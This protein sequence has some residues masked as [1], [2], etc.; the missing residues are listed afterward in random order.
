M[1]EQPKV[2]LFREKSLEAVES[3]ESLNDYLRV[4]SVGVWLV[5]SAVIALLVG[6][7]LWG[8]LGRIDTKRQA[9]VITTGNKTI[10][11][12]PFESFDE[13]TMISERR[14]VEIGGVAYPLVLGEDG[15]IELGYLEE[16]VTEENRYSRIA[17]VSGLAKED[18][19]A[20]LPVDAS[21]EDGVQPGTVV[22]ESLQ[23]ISLI[24]R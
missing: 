10:C 23:P 1:S 24:L 5:L 9:A 14:T 22:T 20:C 13:L 11:C 6:G 19:V 3:P 15:G 8:I 16:F 2:K 7:I 17:L 12:V 21:F 4:T 18:L